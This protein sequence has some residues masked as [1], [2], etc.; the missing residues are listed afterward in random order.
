MGRLNSRAK[1][2]VR[3]GEKAHHKQHNNQPLTLILS[4]VLAAR[5]GAIVL[6]LLL[7][8]CDGKALSEEA[9]ISWLRDVRRSVVGWLCW[10]L[11][12]VLMSF[13]SALC[14][15]HNDRFR[16]LNHSIP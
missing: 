1:V 11:C 9:E 3:G 4:T 6:G 7:L 10:L 16:N 5:V 8:Y 12:V 2:R 14:L 13:V 15:C